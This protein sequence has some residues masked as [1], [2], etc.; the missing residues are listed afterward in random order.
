MFHV[1]CCEVYVHHKQR[2]AANKNEQRKK[3]VAL[4][5]RWSVVRVMANGN[6]EFLSPAIS[7]HIFFT[8]WREEI[9]NRNRLLNLA[10]RN[11]K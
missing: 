2:Q 11:S 4:R 10:G 5:A 1:P 7:R 9:Q 6:F 3:L 8:I